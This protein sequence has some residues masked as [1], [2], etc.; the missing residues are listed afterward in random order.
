MDAEDNQFVTK[1]NQKVLIKS[2]APDSPIAGM[3]WYDSTNK[4]L[5]QFRNSEWVAY[6]AVHFG[7]SAPTTVQE[8]DVWYDS[9]NNLLKVYN[10]SAWESVI[11]SAGDFYGFS[12]YTICGSRCGL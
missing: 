12:C 4:L 1:L 3:L 9:T 7:T 6:A 8:G 11:T 10:G 5:K 2:S